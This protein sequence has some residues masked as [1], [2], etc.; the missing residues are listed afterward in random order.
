MSSAILRK[1]LNVGRQSSTYKY[2][3]GFVL[4]VEQKPGRIKHL[5][6]DRRTP[7]KSYQ[8]K[9]IH[10]SVD[11]EMLILFHLSSSFSITQNTKISLHAKQKIVK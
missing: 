11:K 1:N 6:L 9:I 5:Q 2:I 3:P 7:E 4:S 8:L 10:F